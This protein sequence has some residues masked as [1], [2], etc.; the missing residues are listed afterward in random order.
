MDGFIEEMRDIDLD[1]QAL[2][3]RKEAIKQKAIEHR[4]SITDEEQAQLRSEKTEIET[5]LKVLEQCKKDLQERA[6]QKEKGEN[7]TMDNAMLH[8]KE[9]MER[10][11]VLNTLEYR[12]AFFKTMQGK[13]LTTEEKRSMTSAAESGG[14]AIPTQTMNMIIGQIQESPTVLNLI[15]V[16]NIPEL[17]SL[18]IEN[19]V[20][21]AAWI[22]ETGD[23]TPSEDKL[24]S[25]TLSAYKL[26]KTVKISAKLK[27]MAIDAFEAWIVG[28]IT[29]KMTAACQK[30]VF[31]GTGVEQ[32]TG[33]NTITWND[34][35]SVSATGAPTYDNL[36]DTEA[37]VGEDY[38][39]N[40]VWVM[41]RKT[42]AM[43]M[44]LKDDQKRPI[45]ERA[46]EDGFVGYLL[47]YPVRL[48][49][50]VKNGEAFLGDWKAA[51]V[52]N[53]AKAIE[54]AVSKEAGFMSGSTIYRGLALV[55]GKPTK[56]E[57]AMAKLIVTE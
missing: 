28:A 51:Y 27:E 7:G 49:K 41:N 38:I 8:F 42:K 11:D 37:L 56:I 24:G 46:V 22:S 50:H 32:P 30:A 43:V 12:S 16:L 26:I 34:T 31:D 4:D 2:I 52:M 36:V 40:A 54:Y 13:E 55:D 18:P 23:S 1:I 14:A 33:L 53:F 17:I 45:F 15:T 44:K 3:A 25:L 47:G 48:N 35:N 39:S 57:G 19:L 9:G 6:N 5:K 20:N 10:A 29:K 21:D